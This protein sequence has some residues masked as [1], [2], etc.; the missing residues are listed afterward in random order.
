MF[1]VCDNFEF[2]RRTKFSDS[3]SYFKDKFIVRDKNHGDSF[4]ILRKYGVIQSLNRDIR[5]PKNVLLKN[6][7]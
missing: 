4:I 3:I 7:V 6:L 5:P 2:L 1:R